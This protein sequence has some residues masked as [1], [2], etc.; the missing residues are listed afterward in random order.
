MDLGRLDFFFYTRLWS[1]DKKAS[2]FPILQSVE[3]SFIR[4]VLPGQT[5]QVYTKLLGV[6]QKYCYIQ[7]Q[8]TVD[9]K[10]V[11]DAR[12]RAVLCNGYGVALSTQILEERNIPSTTPES[13]AQWKHYLTLKTEESLN[14]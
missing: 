1:K 8:F 4:S 9:G 3:I 7:Q 5:V 2:C 14:N 10:L 13:I 12:V 11:A 6:D